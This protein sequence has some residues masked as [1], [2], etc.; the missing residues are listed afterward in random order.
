MLELIP[1]DDEMNRSQMEMMIGDS[2]KVSAKLT[3]AWG[4]DMYL[5][6]MENASIIRSLMCEMR[7]CLHF[8][9]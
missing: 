8:W 6:Y 9:N 2:W 1:D 7:A 5:I 3:G 4:G